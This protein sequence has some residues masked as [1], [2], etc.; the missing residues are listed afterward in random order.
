MAMRKLGLAVLSAGLMVLAGTTV[1]RADDDTIRLGTSNSGTLGTITGAADTEL[2]YWRGGWGGYRGSSYGGY[3]NYGYG[4]YRNYG[5]GGYRNYGYGGYRN[6]GYGGYRNYGYGHHRPYYASYYGGYR[7][8][9]GGYGGYN[10]PYYGGYGYGGYGNGGY[11]YGGYGNGGYGY[12]GYGNGGYGYGGYGN[13]GYGYG[14]YG[15][16]GYYGIGYENPAG[17]D[18]AAPFGQA[19]VQQYQYLQPQQLPAPAV[20]APQ[21]GET[22]PYDGGPQSPVPQPGVAPVQPGATP[23]PT[24]P[25]TGKVVSVPRETTGGV[26]YYTSY[27]DRTTAATPTSRYTYPAYG[28]QVL[29]TV[30]K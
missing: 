27:T 29:P 21:A 24:V 19:P 16:G 17:T 6:Y 8:Y 10:R 25:L 3:R 4:G 7:P 28:D 15:N 30:R 13:G 9:Y 23:Q 18:Y 20:V 2:V 5:Y 26:V 11:G 14:G 22:F 12:G 1:V